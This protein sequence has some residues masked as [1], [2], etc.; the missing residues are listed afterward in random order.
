MKVA[1]RIIE[2]PNKIPRPLVDFVDFFS[3][4]LCF[5]HKGQTY[6]V[7]IFLDVCCCFRLHLKG[8]G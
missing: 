6:K 8:I 7:S 3:L 1:F 4:S 5:P 2:Y